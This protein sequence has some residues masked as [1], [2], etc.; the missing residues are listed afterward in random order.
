MTDL[1]D[2][3]EREQ[4]SRAYRRAA[5]L[6]GQKLGL[7]WRTLP[8]EQVE[9]YIRKIEIGRS[10]RNPLENTASQQEHGEPAD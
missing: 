9:E 6:L 10:K 8:R 2:N 5:R 3:T 7:D 4:D 1:F